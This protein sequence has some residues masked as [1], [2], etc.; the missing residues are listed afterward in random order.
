MLAARTVLPRHLTTQQAA[1]SI[2]RQNN[3]AEKFSVD[4]GGN[5]NAVGM[6]TGSGAGLTGIQFSQLSGTLASSQL[7]GRIAMR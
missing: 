7:A 5:V 2:S 6:F 1:R 3:S 4:G